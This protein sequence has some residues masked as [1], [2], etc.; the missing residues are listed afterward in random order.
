MA[1]ICA[2][3]SKKKNTFS[4]WSL[5][6]P[7]NHCQSR[8]IFDYFGQTKEELGGISG[9]SGEWLTFVVCL[10]VGRREEDVRP[11]VVL[12]PAGTA[13]T[14]AG[15]PLVPAAH[16]A[17]GASAPGPTSTLA[18]VL[19]EHQIHREERELNTASSNQPPRPDCC[20]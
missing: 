2:K 10:E 12:V 1:G 14:F 8:E 15:L 13:V 6:F 7:R 20:R 5:E 9:G 16:L 19:P 11:V 18:H 4:R 17:L 3:N